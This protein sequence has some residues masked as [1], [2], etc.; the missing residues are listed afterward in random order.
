MDDKIGKS[1][2]KIRALPNFS[3]Y[4]KFYSIWNFTKHNSPYTY[5]KVKK[6]WPELLYSKEKD[7]WFDL[8]SQ[9]E[10]LAIEYLRLNDKI[11]TAVFDPLLEFYY[12]F[13][14]LCYNEPKHH[15]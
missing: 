1:E 2:E 4:D 13:C 9:S 10:H 5:E 8:D 3:I 11:I 15:S 12:E 7:E 14:E 6:H